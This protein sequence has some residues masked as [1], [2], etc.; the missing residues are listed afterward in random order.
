MSSANL[1]E[2]I[3]SKFRQPKH[4]SNQLIGSLTLPN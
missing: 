1:I 3:R 4:S 2:E